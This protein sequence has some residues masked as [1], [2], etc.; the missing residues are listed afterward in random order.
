LKK[1]RANMENLEIVI[2][3]H[4]AWI[5]L[6]RPAQANAIHAQMWDE[7]GAAFRQMDADETVRVVVLSGAGGYFSAGI[8]F[9]FVGTLVAEVSAFPEGRRQEALREKILHLQRAFSDVEKCRKPVIAMIHGACVGAGLDLIAA[10][11][12]RLTCEGAY[13]CL[14]E[15]DL[16]LVADVGSLQRLPRIVGEGKV[17]EWALT[18]KKIPAKEALESRLVNE[19]FPDEPAMKQGATLLAQTIAS[20]SPLAVRG[21]KTVMNYSREHSTADGLDYVATWNAGMLLSDEGREAVAAMMER[22]T[23]KFE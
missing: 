8:D 15:I 5:T 4:I 17:R 22:R 21:V 23:P 19:V 7:I 20:K 1:V 13:F 6:N 18:A 3:N 2:E 9:G 11:D 12:L 10:C 14:K 16:G